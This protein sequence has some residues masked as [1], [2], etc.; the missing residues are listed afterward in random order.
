M[1]RSIYAVSYDVDEKVQKEW[2]DWMTGN[3]IPEVV[4]SG[5]F[6]R[7]TLFRLKE[8]QSSFLT[9]YEADNV[10][11]IDAYLSGNA[12]RLR[13]DYQKHFGN[14]SRLNRMIL[15]EVFSYGNE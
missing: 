5:K 12:K 4:K 3:H 8:R 9:L 15:Q 2:Q 14:K 13:E 7:A 11:V 1:A 10:E 6:K